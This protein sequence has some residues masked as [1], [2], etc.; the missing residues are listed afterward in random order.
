MA[1][2]L[3]G[4]EHHVADEIESAAL[5]KDRQRLAADLVEDSDPGRRELLARPAL[6]RAVQFEPGLHRTRGTHDIDRAPLRRQLVAQIQEKRRRRS[7]EMF[8]RSKVE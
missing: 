1:D 6:M 7:I 2:R 5:P 8:D 4:R 3:C